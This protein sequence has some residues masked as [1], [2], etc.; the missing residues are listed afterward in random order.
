MRDKFL[1]HLVSETKW[2]NFDNNGQGW[3]PHTAGERK[4]LLVM[5][6]KESGS[7]SPRA[8]AGCKDER[9]KTGQLRRLKFWLWTG[10]NDSHWLREEGQLGRLGGN[11]DLAVF[12]G[13]KGEVVICWGEA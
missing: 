10:P 1:V 3:H 13:L 6:S 9:R 8:P 7:P 11:L 5:D 2:A 12:L 4:C